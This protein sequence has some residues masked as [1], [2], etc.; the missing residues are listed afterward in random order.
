MI[1][2]IAS[3]LLSGAALLVTPPTV[4]AQ[5]GDSVG[6]NMTL[7]SYTLTMD[8]LREFK[9]A[10]LNI[11]TYARTHADE[12]QKWGDLSDN[13]SGTLDD[14]VRRIET[15]PPIKQAIVSTGLT[16]RDYLLTSITFFQAGMAA[17]V[18]DSYAKTNQKAPALPGNVNPANV[19][20]VRAHKTDIEQL[21]LGELASGGG[22]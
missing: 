18:Q 15:I 8:R 6:Y 16:T 7:R 13:D 21:K 10:G 11:E 1:R 14:Q 19:R 20:F 17:A 9:Q 3:L 5:G 2:P 4:H 22:N 12:A